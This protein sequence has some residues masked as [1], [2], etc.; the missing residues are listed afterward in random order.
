MT[1][2][3]RAARARQ[4]LQQH[5][6][7]SSSQQHSSIRTVDES[8][9]N[10][11]AGYIT[12]Q[13]TETES[14]QTERSRLS[15]T[16]L[17]ER[18]A[19]DRRT[20]GATVCGDADV[21][22][23]HIKEVISVIGRL[24]GLGL[25]QLDI[26]LPKCVVLG[27]QSSGKSSIIEAISGIRTPRATGTC[28]RCP[29]FIRLESSSDAEAS[30]SAHV[31]LRYNYQYDV[32]ARTGKFPGWKPNQNVQ[33]VKF[34]D[35]DSPE[36]L[37]DVI[38]CAQLALLH[39][40][41]DPA[42]FAQGRF[43]PLEEDLGHAVNFSPNIVCIDVSHSS[44]PNLSFYDL[45]GL[46]S[47]S[48]NPADVPLVKQLV[49]DYVQDPDAL[50]LVACSLAADIA[51]SMA[52]GLA[53][54]EWGA[55]D[56]CVGVLTKP[57]LLPAGSSD[58][59]L[60]KVLN[61]E[62]LRFDH[63][64]FVV[65]NPDQVML[66]DRLSRQDA[67]EQERQFFATTKPWCSSLKTYQG[68]FG[69]TNLQ[70]YLSEKLAR[71]MI[72]A[73]PVIY[74]QVKLRLDEV[75]EQL[76]SVPEP[77]AIA[78]A[79]RIISDLLFTFTEHVRKEME[80]EYPYKDWNTAWT[81]MQQKFLDGLLAMKP[82]MRTLGRLDQGIYKST[83][84]G[85][86][87]ED[88]MCLEDEDD[89]EHN[90][91]PETPQKKRK[92]EGTPV[93]TP[94]K[95]FRS[96]AAATPSTPSKKKLVNGIDY[97]DKGTLYVLDEVAKHLAENS[98]SKIHDQLQPLVIND[99]IKNT[100]K[101]WHIPLEKLFAELDNQLKSYIHHIFDKYFK[102]HAST[103]L[104]SE[105]WRIVENAL[106]TSMAEQCCTMAPD[107]LHDELEGP[108]M[109]HKKIFDDARTLLRGSYNI[110]R[111]NARIKKYTEEMGEHIGVE[112]VPTEE[113][114]RKDESLCAI[115]RTDPYDKQIDVIAR[116]TSYYE[117]AAH[118]FHDIICMRIEGKLFKR[119][120]TKLR[121]AMDETLGIHGIDGAQKAMALLAVSSEHASLRKQLMT[122]KSALQESQRHLD[123]LQRKHGDS[124]S[125]SGASGFAVPPLHPSGPFG[126]PTSFTDAMQGD[127]HNH[128]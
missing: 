109:F 28:T 83:L 98:R 81:R 116:I 110:A 123:E 43:T 17:P 78:G 2:N 50:V 128:L 26:Q 60:K 31:T 33:E 22:G 67:R 8:I 125:A 7:P 4:K 32:L 21:L 25:S 24:E 66:N 16:P 118:R 97:S 3:T 122:M 88:P 108:Y 112:R 82:T 65:K 114:L 12:P 86:S 56:R 87:S 59:P 49:Q 101:N 74:E 84:L 42:V 71:Q 10:G 36:E 95:T 64:Y 77:P 1:G 113:R 126:P 104:Y 6:V 23:V 106:D 11:D 35:C 76:K 19:G 46:I 58:A 18:L 93:P 27:E 39:P 124:I 29:L 115:L 99:M 94:T 117:V 30:W 53:R 72:K 120:R 103:K 92:F 54:F 111:F 105:A 61:N 68:R 5:A 51:T 48:E 102:V 63:G 89:D 107:A 34:A 91:P 45:P 121:D 40:L 20:S 57:D 9:V 80:P 85:S 15:H 70:R 75:D 90:T 44:L 41:E 127:M 119:L 47:Q 62:E 14:L 38:R 52:S 79:A 73:L 37:E 55:A 13:Q 96:R 69:N 100:L